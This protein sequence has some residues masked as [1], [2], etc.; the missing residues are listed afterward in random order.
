MLPMVDSLKSRTYTDWKWGDG[1]RYSTNR[2][3]NKARVAI[4][5][6][7][8][9][10]FKIMRQ[11]SKLHNDGRYWS[12]NKYNY[13]NIYA[14]QHRRTSMYKANVDRHKR[15]NW[16]SHIDSRGFQHPTYINGQIIQDRNISKKTQAL[17]DTLDY[18]D[19]LDI[20]WAF[21]LKTISFK[22]TWNILQDRSHARPQ[23]KPW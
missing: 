17:N 11:R 15:R 19:W 4:L 22:C 16:Q 23:I 12:K 20:F 18:M 9:I 1:R 3:Q 14:F 21:Y 13:P 5:I 8:K 2:N 6:S 10:N 7:G